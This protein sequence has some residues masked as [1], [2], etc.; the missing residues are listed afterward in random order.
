MR[1]Y[2]SQ[3]LDYNEDAARKWNDKRVNCNGTEQNG[4]VAR[5]YWNGPGQP[6]QLVVDWDDSQL[7]WARHTDA[8][9]VTI[10]REV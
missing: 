6:V 10:I 4:T 5:A 9:H 3:I 2:V 8:E 1:G 7:I